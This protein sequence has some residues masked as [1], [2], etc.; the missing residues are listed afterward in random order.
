[1]DKKNVLESKSLNRFI[2]ATKIKI[3]YCTRKDNL[4]INIK[5]VFGYCKNTICWPLQIQLNDIMTI[6]NSHYS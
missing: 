1:M 6:L 3:I 2:Y 5:K 4:F